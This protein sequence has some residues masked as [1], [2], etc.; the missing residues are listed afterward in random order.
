[1]P[2]DDTAA[3]PGDGAAIMPDNDSSLRKHSIVIAGH[4]TSF[5]LENIF[6]DELKKIARTS[7]L[8]L[9]SLVAQIDGHRSG[10]LSSALRVFILKNHS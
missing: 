6:W 1:M 10:N 4:P 3:M 5:T 7:N 9:S 8:S 2:D